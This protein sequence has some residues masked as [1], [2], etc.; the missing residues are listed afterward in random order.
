MALGQLDLEAPR[1][2]GGDSKRAVEVLEKGLR[3]GETNALYHLRLAQAYLAV[4]REEDAR[5]QLT[6]LLD[7]KPGPDYLPEY[8][9]AATQAR[10]LLEEVK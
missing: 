7:M 10:R 3:Y 4:N 8:N 9:D 1:M 2:M 6:T 5:R